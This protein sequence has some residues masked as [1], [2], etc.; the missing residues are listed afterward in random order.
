L[1]PWIIFL[2]G[3]YTNGTGQRRDVRKRIWPAVK[4][5]TPF[6]AKSGFLMKTLVKARL[7]KVVLNSLFSQ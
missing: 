7:G 5:C 2:S 6:M 4:E 3:A 1:E